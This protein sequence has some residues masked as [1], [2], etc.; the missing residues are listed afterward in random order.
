MHAAADR[1]NA[2]EVWKGWPK[3]ADWIERLEAKYAYS[4]EWRDALDRLK[5]A[6]G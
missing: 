3:V 5:G 2:H 1:A 6:T 4:S